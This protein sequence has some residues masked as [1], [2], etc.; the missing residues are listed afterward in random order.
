MIIPGSLRRHD[1]ATFLWRI[2]NYLTN[3]ENLINTIFI[4]VFANYLKSQHRLM[5]FKPLPGYFSFVTAVCLGRKA[6]IFFK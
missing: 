2:L 1:K 5:A 4:T 6:V 3:N